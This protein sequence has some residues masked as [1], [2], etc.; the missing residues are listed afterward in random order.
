M[1][2]AIVRDP[3]VFLFDEPLSNLDAKLRVQMRTEIKELHQRLKTTS[4][5]VTHDQIE[6]MTM[7]DKI[8]VMRDGVVEQTGDPLELY[9]H[10]ANTFV[11]GF[12]GSPA[13]NMIPGTART[14]AGAPRVEFGDGV[15]LPVPT[16]ARADDGQR[17]L[18]GLRP[19]HCAIGA[20]GLPVE[21]VVVEPT[22]ADTQLYCRF[23]GQEVTATI[24]DRTNCRPGDRINLAP[25][26]GRAHLFDAASGKRLAA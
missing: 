21:V 15:A 11:A 9:D 4:I 24:D 26:L 22:G 20:T 16:D 3:Q 14:T 6:A 5:Y 12:I 18:Y 2:R 1:G 10:P 25:D 17:V 13:M 8:V 7:A 23:N 19:E